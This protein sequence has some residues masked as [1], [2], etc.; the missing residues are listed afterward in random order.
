M[1]KTTKKKTKKIAPGKTP[2]QTTAKTGW[3]LV[4]LTNK[5]LLTKHLAVMLKSGLT[6]TEALDIILD[7][8]QG[9]LKKVIEDVR[10]Q[11]VGGRSLAESFRRHPKIFSRMFTSVIEVGENS[12][13]LTRSLEELADQLEKEHELKVKIYQA[14]L[15]PMIVLIA[16]VLVGAGISIFV[17]PK[18]RVLFAI[19]KGNLPLMTQILLFIIDIFSKYGLI[20][21]PGIVIG[22]ILLGLLFQTKL[23]KPFWHRII[24]R[25]PLVSRF[26]KNLNLA[27]F[28]RNLGILLRSGL[29]ITQALQI[30]AGVLDNEIYKRKVLEILIGVRQ[31][32]SVS[33]MM[34]RVD[35]VFPK[36]TSR[37]IGVGEK[38][39]KLDEVLLYLARF[40]EGEV[41]KL[42]KTLSTTLEPI[43]L[44]IIGLVVGFVMLA[45]M[46]PI[47]NLTSLVAGG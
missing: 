7:Q 6:L 40:Y 20:I 35:R 17:L 3:G 10:R 38:S 36:I 42:S 15:Y 27:R 28:N 26:S 22:I 1:P 30:V 45:I 47:Y 43:L 34:V 24:L 23:M 37:M 46:T 19:F 32:K 21:F 25:L 5:V 41:D 12:G 8:S 33:A 39:G 9:K 16:V 4:S 44:I 13:T 2:K 31:G 14:M 29:P 11:A 18:L